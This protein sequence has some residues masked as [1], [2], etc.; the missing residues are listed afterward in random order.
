MYYYLPKVVSMEKLVESLTAL[1]FTPTEARVY[2]VLVRD[3]EGTGYQAARSLGLSRS[4]VYAAL[5]GLFAAG[6]V[7]LKDGETSVYTA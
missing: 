4:S 2:L 3:G 6:A 7:Y 5:D 1:G